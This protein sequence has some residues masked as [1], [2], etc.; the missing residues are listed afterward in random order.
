[1][2]A[3]RDAN[4]GFEAWPALD[5]LFPTAYQGINPNRGL[6]GTVIDTDRQPLAD[7]IR[8]YFAAKSFEDA[9][10]RFP[11]LADQYAGYD[12][13]QVWE[14][15]CKSGSDET[16]TVPLDLRWL[17][18]ETESK[19]LNR[20]RP[21]LAANATQNEFLLAV[22]QPRRVSEARPVLTGTTFDLHVHDRGSVGFPRESQ[23]GKLVERTA[24]LR[25]EAWKALR[26]A[27]SHP[28]E[29]LADAPARQ[30]VGE[31]FRCALAI[32]HSP[33]YEG[34]HADALAQ[35][36]AHVPIPKD[37][38]LFAELVKLGH[39]IS[40]LLDPAIASDDTIQQILGE[41]ATH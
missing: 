23:P 4:V 3:P 28:G 14:S 11:A 17:Y 32:L 36:W 34:D 19:L 2:F 30:L 35:D 25:L 41:G 21:E 33:Q 18:Y 13:K 16:K 27:W 1:M 40:T 31:L 26:A 22:P 12:A 38:M 7:R 37:R 10:Q 29:S 8:R 20:P 15:L 24:N 9:A 5:E 39:M 6:D